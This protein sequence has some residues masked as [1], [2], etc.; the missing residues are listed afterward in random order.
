MA[1]ADSEMP[2][3][4]LRLLALHKRMF[5][6]AGASDILQIVSCNYKRLGKETNDQW[7]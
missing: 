7:T 1:K 5:S 6:L 2:Q 3:G 4:M